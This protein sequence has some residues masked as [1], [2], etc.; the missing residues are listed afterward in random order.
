MVWKE[1]DELS[2][3]ILLRC[4]ILCSRSV[5]RVFPR[6]LDFAGYPKM[7]NINTE[8]WFKDLVSF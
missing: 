1:E 4:G 3:H 7:S 5:S 2:C 6:D 8:A